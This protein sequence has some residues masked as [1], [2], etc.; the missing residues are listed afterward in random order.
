MK[1]HPLGHCFSFHP[2]ISSFFLY[3]QKARK[4]VRRCLPSADH[5]TTRA[6]ANVNICHFGGICWENI[7][8]SNTR[9]IGTFTYKIPYSG[10]FMSVTKN[11][12]NIK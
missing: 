2:S 6:E 8:V 4:S 9:Y 10:F 3:S 1:I 7:L 12:K 5:Q 11:V